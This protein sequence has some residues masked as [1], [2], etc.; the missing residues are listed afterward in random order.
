MFKLY[1]LNCNLYFSDN[2]AIYNFL[3]HHILPFRKMA[4]FSESVLLLPKYTFSPVLAWLP[5]LFQF[6]V[7][8]AYS[9]EALCPGSIFCF[10]KVHSIGEL[11]TI[12]MIMISVPAMAWDYV[13]QERSR[14]G[15]SKSQTRSPESPYKRKRFVFS[16]LDF[17]FLFPWATFIPLQVKSLFIK[18]I[19]KD[20]ATV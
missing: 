20:W 19:E 1:V 18:S 11:S 14:S 12:I 3:S 2:D 16:L 15:Y 9:G 10:Q 4:W 7:L 8:L 13:L 17:V 6:H 5:E